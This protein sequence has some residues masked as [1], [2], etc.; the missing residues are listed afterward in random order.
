MHYAQIG[1][2]I[3]AEGHSESIHLSQC[4][5]DA[6]S[7]KARLY[8]AIL[9]RLIGFTSNSIKGGN[10]TLTQNT[11]QTAGFYRSAS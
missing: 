1:N 10:T 2:A 7:G 9:T 8:L 6:D 4:A 3:S 5:K 11:A